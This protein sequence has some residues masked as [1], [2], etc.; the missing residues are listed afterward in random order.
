MAINHCFGV[1]KR[2]KGANYKIT[3]FKGNAVRTQ[4]AFGQINSKRGMEK[5]LAIKGGGIRQAHLG[6]Q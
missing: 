1:I 3:V 4:R 6:L 2:N 5:C